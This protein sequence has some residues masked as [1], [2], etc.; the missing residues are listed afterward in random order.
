[1]KLLILL[2]IFTGFVMN[3]QSQKLERIIR[4][5]EAAEKAEGN[6]KAEILNDLTAEWFSVNLDSANKF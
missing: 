5:R 2:L 1:M 3:G 6:R 4:L